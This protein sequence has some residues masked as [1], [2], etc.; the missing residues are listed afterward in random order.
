LND[1]G[2]DA[3][4]P[5]PSI[6]RSI[7]YEQ[8]WSFGLQKELPAKIVVDAT[9]V[10][11]K[12]THLYL[13]GFRNQ[14]HLGPQFEQLLKSGQISPNQIQQLARVDVNNPLAPYITDP[15]SSLSAPTIHPYQDPSADGFN[16]FNGVLANIPFPQFSSFS[17]D[18]PPI[19]NSVYHAAQFRAEKPFGNGLEFLV[20]YTI[21]KSIDNASTTDDSISWLGGG[22]DGDT[23]HVQDPNNLRAERAL[24]AFDIP[25]VLQL[26]YVYSLPVGRGQKFGATMHP[27]LNGL[28]GGWQ[29]NG[30]WRIASGRP[31]ILVESDSI[32]HEIPTYGQR[33]TITGPLQVNHSSTTSMVN[34]YFANACDTE[35]CPNGGP[36]VLVQTTPFTLG[37]V[38]RTYG[39]VRTPPVRNVSMA[40]FKEFPMA[41]IR[42]GMRIEFRAEA[43]NVFNH[44]QF[45]APDTQLGDGTF[46]QITSTANSNRELQLGLKLYF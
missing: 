17:G 42:E 8:A 44:P 29:L 5:I 3:A 12:G 32:R 41:S 33:P 7:P 13:G 11:K 28:L 15:L 4:G 27:V 20:T 25:Q 34:N 1:V 9:Y 43:F 19:A 2:F 31:V 16:T 36:S 23:L 21:S 38:P 10:G 40:L 18:S 30:I 46:G 6:S 26:S 45:D 35:P 24:S 22:L 37:N 39:G 14:N